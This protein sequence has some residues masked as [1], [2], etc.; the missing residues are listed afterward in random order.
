M[1][2]FLIRQTGSSTPS[3]LIG[4]PSVVPLCI[5]PPAPKRGVR[6]DC[7]SPEELCKLATGW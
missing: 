7:F 3:T 1:P 2:L 4:P 6:L 5:P